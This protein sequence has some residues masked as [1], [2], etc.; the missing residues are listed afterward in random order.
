MVEFSIITVTRN[1]AATLERSI[2]SVAEQ[3]HRPCDYI[4]VDGASTDATA[5]IVDK[6]AHVVT[7]FV[8][9]PDRGIYDAMNKGLALARGDFIYF[10]GADDRLI[11]SEVLADVAASLDR[12][13]CDFLYG[14]IEVRFGDGRVTSFM[15]PPPEEA[16]AF[17]VTGCLPHQASFASRRA[18][19]RA[20]TF[21]ARYRIAGDYDWFLRVLTC[22]G[23]LA[24]RIERI[25]ASY[26]MG[27]VSNRLRP[28]QAEVYAIQ[29][30]LP[31][32]QRDDWLRR[33][34]RVYQRALVSQYRQ[35]GVALKLLRAIIAYVAV[36]LGAGLAP[37]RWLERRLAQLQQQVLEARI[38]NDARNGA[39]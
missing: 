33:R 24:R 13:P 25:I 16:L 19:D 12:E 32:Y 7:R 4:I 38:A 22:D 10:L 1:A 9:E 36:A 28:S 39:G 34:V 21:D 15:P 2:Q 30:A 6:Y 35:K 23:L 8:S 17:M 18:F 31:L 14:G 5:A 20:G 11:D 27:G 29:N 37:R 3:R 26:Q